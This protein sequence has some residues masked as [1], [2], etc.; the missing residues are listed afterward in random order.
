VHSDCDTRNETILQ[1]PLPR[2]QNTIARRVEFRGRGMFHGIETTVA[3][4]PAESD[5]GISF[6][7]TDLSD[8]LPIPAACSLIA[9]EP[10]RTVLAAKKDARVETV[11]HLMAAMAGLQVD[12]CIVEIDAPEVPGFDGSCRPF[13]D[14]ILS[15]GTVPLDKDASH[16]V[17]D[18]IHTVQSSDRAQTLVLRP[19]LHRCLA[20]TYHLDY[21]QLAAVPPQTMS[22]EIS[23]EFFYTEISA[24]RTFVLESE[25]SMLQKMGYGKHLTAQ[26][27]VV[28]GKD[29]IL[30]NSLRWPDEAVRHKILDCIGDLALAGTSLYGHV[31]ANR[32]GH[33]LNHELAKTVS[34]L[35]KRQPSDKAAA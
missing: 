19:Y 3:L 5:T 14:E 8:S 20:I 1:I 7:R 28:V 27:I 24:A 13:C 10:R 33:H 2:R 34:T 9:T 23:P 17:V 18:D 25:I 12:N 31:T 11:E 4:L 15:A 21:G 30:D 6:R 26:D 32:S 29:G 35:N 16:V 22:A